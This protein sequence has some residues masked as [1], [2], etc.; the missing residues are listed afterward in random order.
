MTSTPTAIVDAGESGIAGV[1]VDLYRDLNGNGRLDPGEPKI[2]TTTTDANG[3]Y[4]FSGLPTTGGNY[5]VDVTDS[6]SVLTGWWHSLG[7]PGVDNNS[8]SDPYA[9]TLTAGAPNNTTADFGYFIE[10]GAVGNWVWQETPDTIYG[11]QDPGEVGIPL[12]EVTLTIPWPGVTTPTVVKTLTDIDGSYRFGNLLLDEQYDG[13]GA[14]EPTYVISINTGQGALNG[15]L[16]SPID[17]TGY[18]TDPLDTPCLPTSPSWVTVTDADDSDDPDGTSATA[19]R[20][21]TDTSSSNDASPINWTDFGFYTTDT[22]P[23]SLSF[24]T[25]TRQ[26]NR[27]LVEWSTATE[28]GNAG[29]NLYAQTSTGARS[30]TVG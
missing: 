10:G 17:F 6:A 11:K 28:A 12:V 16:V 26:G 22:T 27:V 19:A 1:T 21:Q 29:F 4:L 7:T 5:I 18:C 24:F 2:G 9:V 15:L 3:A 23:V 30:S 25:A 20:G 13:A 8:Q 14:G